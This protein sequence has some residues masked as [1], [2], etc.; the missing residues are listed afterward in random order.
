MADT[1]D[2]TALAQML[3]GSLDSDAAALGPQLLGNS[4]P[5]AH[6]VDR[7]DYLAYIRQGWF[8]GFPGMDP[9][10]FRHNLI[11][12]VG[13]QSAVDTAKE[14][15]TGHED[16]YAQ[17]YTAYQQQQMA[18]QQPPPPPPQG[19]PM[20]APLGQQPSPIPSNGQ[21]G[22]P[23]A[24]SPGGT[25]PGN[26]SMAVPPPAGGIPGPPPMMP[27]AGPMAS[28]VPMMIPPPPPPMGG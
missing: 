11:M 15:W 8:Q 17:A 10:E 28:P 16:E 4:Q 23:Q 2:I 13:N 21:M 5:D 14:A 22:P 19:P 6:K 9:A 20:G 3:R 27:P 24:L 25:V 1:H 12:R 7:G 18:Q 26:G